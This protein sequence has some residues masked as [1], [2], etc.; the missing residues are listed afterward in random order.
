MTFRGISAVTYTGLDAHVIQ[1]GMALCFPR[2]LNVIIQ[3]FQPVRVSVLK[4]GTAS[5]KIV[6]EVASSD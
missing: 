2:M 1:D 5:V 4:M 6:R 3:W